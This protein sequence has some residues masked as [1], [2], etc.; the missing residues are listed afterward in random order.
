VFSGLQ[1][2][3]I[4][5]I[6]VAL[7]GVGYESTFSVLVYECDDPLCEVCDYNLGTGLGDICT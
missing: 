2:T 3:Y 6:Y 1:D 5:G 7:N 4:N